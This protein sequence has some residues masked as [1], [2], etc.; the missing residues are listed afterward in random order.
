MKKG[1]LNISCANAYETYASIYPSESREPP[2]GGWRSQEEVGGIEGL[3]SWEGLG[4]EGMM[5]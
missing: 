2:Q 4:K 3:L 5:G 1:G